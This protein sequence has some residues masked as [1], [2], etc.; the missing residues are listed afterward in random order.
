MHKTIAE[1]FDD[2]WVETSGPLETPCWIWQR[3][4]SKG[5]GKLQKPRKGRRGITAAAHRFSFERTNGQIPVGICVCHACDAPLCVNP[6]HLFLATHQE[7]MTDMTN[8][9][10]KSTGT[11][12]HN[13]KFSEEDIETI[14]KDERTQMVI[15]AELGV[16]QVAIS[17]MKTGKTYGA[18]G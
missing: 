7:N 8:K 9:G 2:H 17:N 18:E 16:S 14:L 1:T 15:A 5:Y 12:S 13:S 10:R 4:T 6:L 3:G 11:R